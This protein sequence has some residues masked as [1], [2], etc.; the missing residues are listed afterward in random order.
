MTMP[1][2]DTWTD[3]PLL[4][5]SGFKFSQLEM[6]TCCL[7]FPPLTCRRSDILHIPLLRGRPLHAPLWVQVRAFGEAFR[8]ELRR[9]LLPG[10]QLHELEARDGPQSQPRSLIWGLGFLRPF[11]LL[12]KVFSAGICSHR[13]SR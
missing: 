9:D 4:G 1:G 10:G 5:Y 13:C 2:V 3:G 6:S 11:S 8:V 7:P 12:S